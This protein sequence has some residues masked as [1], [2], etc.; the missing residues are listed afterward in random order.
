[1]SS[2]PRVECTY[3]YAVRI[4][5]CSYRLRERPTAVPRNVRN[6]ENECPESHRFV[7]PLIHMYNTPNTDAQDLLH[8]VHED[9]P[10]NLPGNQCSVP[11]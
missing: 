5:L 8:H 2:N 1:M 6:P 9:T 3:E 11:T 4:F 7:A 10:K